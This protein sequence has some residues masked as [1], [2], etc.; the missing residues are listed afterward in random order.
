M[1]LA[2][3]QEAGSGVCQGLPKCICIEITEQ[4][5]LGGE[6]EPCPAAG[7]PPLQPYTGGKRSPESEVWK[8]VAQSHVDGEQG[9][10]LEEL[11][12]LCH[13]KKSE[14]AL[15]FP[16]RAVEKTAENWS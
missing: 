4:P 2:V 8:E 13:T 16:S 5:M 3:G 10:F 7:D 12:S 15:V 14:R 1:C 11:V 9:P 6:A